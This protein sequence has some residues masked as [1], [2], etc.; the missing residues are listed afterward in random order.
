VCGG[1]LDHGRRRNGPGPR[2]DDSDARIHRH[3]HVRKRDCRRIARPDADGALN[4]GPASMLISAVSATLGLEVEVQG[5]AGARPRG[6]SPTRSVLARSDR[7]TLNQRK[8]RSSYRVRP[9]RPKPWETAIRRSVR[10]LV[11]DLLVGCSRYTASFSSLAGRNAIFLLA[12]ILMAAPVAR[13]RPILAA[14]FRT[15]RM[16]RP[17][18]RIL[19]PLFSALPNRP[20][21]PQ[22]V[23]S[24]SRG[25]RPTRRR[26]A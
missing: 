11:T 24:R 25:C 1:A 3:H 16:P 20:A 14:R 5:I 26:G 18:R 10:R 2:P 21:R 23:S 13:L 12:L 7:R 22:P 8:P 6:S 15:W 4:I 17:V 19:S 9:D